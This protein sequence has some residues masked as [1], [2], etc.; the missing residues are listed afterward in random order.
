VSGR[1]TAVDKDEGRS[2]VRCEV[3]CQNQNSESV[4][5]GVAEVKVKAA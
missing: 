2:R 3:L 4:L 1:I 5:T